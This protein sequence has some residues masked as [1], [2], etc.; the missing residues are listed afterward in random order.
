MSLTWNN[1]KVRTDLKLDT[2]ERQ[3]WWDSVDDGMFQSMAFGTM[4]VG[5]NNIKDIFVAQE[6][7]RRHVMLYAASGHEPFLTLEFLY[8]F[9][10]F[11]TNASTKT[12]A[13]F[14]K[15]CNETLSRRADQKLQDAI[16]AIADKAHNKD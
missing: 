16:N 2:P 5:I 6:F 9:I 1:L 3:E 8:D 4:S 11:R 7:Y 10:G 15:H 13:E 14:R 12:P